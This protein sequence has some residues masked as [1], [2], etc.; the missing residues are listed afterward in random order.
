[1]GG[2]LLFA[3]N[4]ELPFVLQIDALNRGLGA[5][6]SQEVDSEVAAP[7]PEACGAGGKVQHVEKECLAIKWAVGTLRSCLLGCALTLCLDHDPLHYLHCMKDTGSVC[8]WWVAG[9]IGLTWPTL[10]QAVFASSLLSS[11]P[12]C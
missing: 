6:L 8:V 10:P 1:V 3:S 12:P 4:F 9:F 5:I 7:Q 2:A 11:L